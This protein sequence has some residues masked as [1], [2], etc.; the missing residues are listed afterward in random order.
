[1]KKTIV[2]FGCILSCLILIICCYQPIHARNNPNECEKHS[3]TLAINF[4]HPHD[5]SMYLGWNSIY[6][7]FK[8]PDMGCTIIIGKNVYA[9]VYGLVIRSDSNL[10]Y[11]DIYVNEELEMTLD[12]PTDYDGICQEWQVHWCP[13]GYNDIR[14]MAID[15]HNNRFNARQKLLVI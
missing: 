6:L 9:A 10:S 5:K 13:S 1:M 8:Y 12:E 7:G 14:L 3:N 4:L 11:I 15:E 2:L